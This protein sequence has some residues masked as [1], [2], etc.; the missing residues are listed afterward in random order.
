[1]KIV[2][3]K[4]RFDTTKA[5]RHIK[6]ARWNGSNHIL[7]NLW[8]SSTGTFYMEEPAQWSNHA[9]NYRLTTPEEILQKYRRFLR[10]NEIEELASYVEGW[11]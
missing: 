5:K 2:I 11:E 10:E 7:G 9:G 4:K 3:D 1:M 8:I 6:L